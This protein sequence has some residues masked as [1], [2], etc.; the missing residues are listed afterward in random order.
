VDA[1]LGLDARVHSALHRAAMELH[2]AQG[3]GAHMSQFYRNALLFLGYTP[4]ASVSPAQR[5]SLASEIALSALLGEEIFNFGELL[6]HDILGSLAGTPHAWVHP[7]LTAF[8]TGDIAAFDAC[9]RANAGSQAALA[10]NAAFLQQ[11]IRLMALVELAFGL[12]ADA[13][14]IAFARVAAHCQ[15]EAANVELLLMKAMSLGLVRGVI[16][17]VDETVRV[18]WAQ[19][20][21]LDK[22]QI[23]AL[24]DQMGAW[25]AHVDRTSAKLE[26]NAPELFL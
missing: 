6:Q 23:V 26:A 17:Q 18:T 19:P 20:R 9:M 15:L 16:D 21:V 14:T 2:K 22:A 10:N 5:V 8:S 3:G 25:A 13:R 4:A 1:A 24:R 12:A 11:K 7:L